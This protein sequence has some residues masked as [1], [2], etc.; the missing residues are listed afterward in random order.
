MK[1][2]TTNQ[3]R[4]ITTKKSLRKMIKTLIKKDCRILHPTLVRL[5]RVKRI[6]FADIC[7]DHSDY[8]KKL[9]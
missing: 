5:I 1:S 9:I 3:V 8:L 7:L 2:V 4:R 6:P